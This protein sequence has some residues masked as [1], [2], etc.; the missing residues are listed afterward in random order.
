MNRPLVIIA[1][2]TAVGKTDLAVNLAKKING[3]VISADSAQVYRGMNIG[4]AKINIDEMQGV[5][6]H[7]IDILNPDEPFSVADFKT[8][9]INSYEDIISRGKI[10]ILC[11]GT[12]FYI[13]ALLYDIDFSESEGQITEY[14]N[15]LYDILNSKGSDYLYDMLTKVDPVSCKTIHKNDTKRV[16]RALEYYHDTGL[17][18]SEHNK[19]Q[20]MREPA[21][22]AE[23][24][25]LNDYRE[26]I[27]ANIDKRV[28]LMIQ[29]G[30]CDEVSSLK[31]TG[32]TKS[33]VSMQ[34]LGYKEILEF[35]DGVISLDEAVYRIKRDSRHFAKRQI[36]WFKRERFV[37]W[38]NKYDFNYDNELILNHI[39]EILYSDNIISRQ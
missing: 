15:E 29:K 20:A 16:V 36:T 2:P 38:I 4:S 19:T 32:L 23:Y 5:K 35:L 3:E 1:G 9:A 33:D 21:F 14:R 26:N 22:D 8:Y 25:V 31:N 11:G 10:P 28:D 27:Y 24:F 17:L 7:L 39:I 13:Q 18:M 6:H 30:L 34:A 12:G 37:Q